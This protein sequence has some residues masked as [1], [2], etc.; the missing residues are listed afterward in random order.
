MGFIT[1]KSM[2]SANDASHFVLFFSPK[3]RVIVQGN[4]FLSDSF[5]VFD[6][7]NFYVAGSLNITRGFLC[8]P[9]F[10]FI[11]TPFLSKLFNSLGLNQT[12]KKAEAW[13]SSPFVDP[14]VGKFTSHKPLTHQ[15]LVGAVVPPW[16]FK[17]QDLGNASVQC[18]LKTWHIQGD[19]ESECNNDQCFGQ[20]W[21]L[22]L[23]HVRVTPSPV[24]HIALDDRVPIV[25]C[26]W[27]KQHPRNKKAK[28]FHSKLCVDERIVFT[29]NVLFGMNEY[30]TFLLEMHLNNGEWST[31]S[32]AGQILSPTHLVYKQE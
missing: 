17:I 4:A 2:N 7:S 18:P 22:E 3:S 11:Y 30:S 13:Y 5:S 28:H 31:W 20:R 16:S 14:A 12:V 29:Q 6:L 25:K 21:R 19:V 26:K 8:I 1:D 32:M 10:L 23:N 24:N 9:V 27:F 15:N